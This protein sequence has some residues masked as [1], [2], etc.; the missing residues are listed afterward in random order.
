MEETTIKATTAQK[1]EAR[2]WTV[3][4]ILVWLIVGSLLL[5]AHR[6]S[7]LIITL[8]GVYLA[9]GIALPTLLL[10]GHKK[11][12]L[13]SPITTAKDRV[14][15]ALIIAALIALGLGAPT[16]LRPGYWMTMG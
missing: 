3:A 1:I 15:F 13:R 14:M 5:V 11:G 6:E 7:I 9:A 10:V 4:I 16:L 12:K 2:A 8:A